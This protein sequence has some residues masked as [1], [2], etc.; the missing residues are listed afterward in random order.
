[1]TVSLLFRLLLLFSHFGTSFGA[2]SS[3]MP[4][5]SEVHRREMSADLLP[6]ESAPHSIE[7]RDWTDLAHVTVHIP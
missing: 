3:L 5:W 4:E 6:V 7:H 2:A 1:M